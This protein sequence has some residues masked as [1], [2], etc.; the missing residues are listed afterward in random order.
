M[1]HEQSPFEF[2]LYRITRTNPRVAKTW[3]FIETYKRII[4]SCNQSSRESLLL[5]ATSGK[6]MKTN[7]KNSFMFWRNWGHRLL[8]RLLGVFLET[9]K[10]SLLRLHSCTLFQCGPPS[11]FTKAMFSIHSREKSVSWPLYNESEEEMIG[12]DGSFS[13]EVWWAESVSVVHQQTVWVLEGSL[14]SGERHT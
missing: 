2:K 9:L 4:A 13:V 8:S 3:F 12:R 11:T 1:S 10:S 6:G 14:C 7:S 5:S